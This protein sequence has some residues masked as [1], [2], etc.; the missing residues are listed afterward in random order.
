MLLSENLPA[1]WSVTMHKSGEFCIFGTAKM[2]M[3]YIPG[4]RSFPKGSEKHPLKTSWSHWSCKNCA[5]H[6]QLVWV[7]KGQEC[8]GIPHSGYQPKA[9]NPL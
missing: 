5:S 9:R 8:Q 7:V 3:Q 1:L 6:P 2:G 4:R